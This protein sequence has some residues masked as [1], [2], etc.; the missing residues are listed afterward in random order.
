MLNRGTA[1]A[2]KYGDRVAFTANRVGDAAEDIRRALGG[3]Y[4]KRGMPGK[5]L[6]TAQKLGLAGV[7]VGGLYLGNRMMSGGPQPYQQMG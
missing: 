4:A 7:G 6:T 5:G 2:E 3:G 1:T